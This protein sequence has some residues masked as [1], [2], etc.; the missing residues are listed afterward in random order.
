MYELIQVSDHDYYIDCPAKIGVVRISDSDV[1]I[2]DSGSD[3]DA[4]KK[5]LKALDE[6]A[7]HLVSIFNT[8]SHADHIGGNK[9]IEERTG[10]SIYANGLEQVY[11]VNP[12]LESMGLYGGLPFKDIQNKFLMAQE[13][14]AKPL[15][16]DVLPLGWQLINLPGHCFDMVGFITADGNAFIADSVSSKETLEKYGMAYL[17][18][19]SASLES[20]EL[21]KTLDANNFVP[22]HAGV[23]QDITELADINIESI[24][25]TFE[26]IEECC[27]KPCAFE[28]IL[29]YLFDRFNMTLTTQQYLLIGSTLRSYLSAMYTKGTLTIS[30]EDNKMLW[31]KA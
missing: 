15:T 3:K 9:L 24:N 26:A 10:C 19:P 20:L 8:H 25:K 18:D 31:T 7:W 29:K 22:A 2:I 5:V 17:W 1:V 16:E 13:S 14:H 11:T 21:L 12:V 6:H 27:S 4:G 23:C 28:D 30:F